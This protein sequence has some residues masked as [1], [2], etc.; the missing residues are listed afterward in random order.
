MK[1]ITLIICLV[2]TNYVALSQTITEYSSGFTSLEGIAINLN[3]EIYVSE[4]DSGKIYHLLSNGTKVEIAT[5]GGYA[6]DMV[7]DANNNLYIAEPFLNKISVINTN[8]LIKS[9]YI[10]TFPNGNSP[11]GLAIY[12]DLLYFSSETSGKVIQINANLTTT[13]YT[14]GLFTPEGIAFDSNGNLYVADRND[15][16]LF[17]ITPTGTKT[18]VASNIT[19]IRGVAVSPTDE[20]YFTSY[21][22]FP[23]E[24]KIMKYNPTTEAISD[25]VITSLDEPR[26]IEIDNLGNMYVTNIGNGTVTKIYDDALLPAASPNDIVNIPDTIFKDYLLNYGLIN[27]NGDD[28]IQVSEAN[29][30][31]GEIYIPNNNISDLTGIEYFTEI[32]SLVCNSNNLISLDVSKNTKL[33]KLSCS[34]NNITSLDVSTNTLLNELYCDSNSISALDI[35]ANTLLNKLYCS[36]NDITSLDVS[37]NTSLTNLNCGYNNITSLDVL[38]NTQLTN[39][40]CNGNDITNLNVSAN[41]L[42]TY[43]N[44]GANDISS[45][46]ISANT[47]LTNLSCGSNNITSLNVSANTLL[48]QLTIDQNDIS[49]IDLST[50]TALINLNTS[51]NPLTTLDV[52]K[53]VSLQ[54]LSCAN[55]GLSTLD[56]SKNINLLSLA[57]II[58]ELTTIDLSANESLKKLDIDRNKLQSLD[59]TK[60]VLLEILDCSQ[61]EPLT[62]I[63]LRNGNNT[64]ITDANFS[65]SSTPNLNCI[66]VDDSTYSTNNWT[67]KDA[68][69]TFI[70]TEAEC[71]T[72]GTSNFETAQIGIYPNP[73]SEILNINTPI[74]KVTIYNTQGQIVLISEMKNVNIQNLPSGLYFIKIIG[75]ND[76]LSTSQFIKQ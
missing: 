46:D 29:S 51:H 70:E 71:G 61:N 36:F 4:H 21:N 43:L 57:C 74:K 48:T 16:K 45:L 28:E 58:N 68:A 30:F 27:V 3:N 35:S 11:Y 23:V 6:N 66:Y 72:L 1:K 20:V 44:C 53:N 2:L 60:N 37:A 12:N 24:N 62:T 5:A 76:N 69:N 10:S 22:S 26:L 64:L 65:S 7:F 33:I 31:N 41:T 38:T 49:S 25:F 39:L 75:I 13:D 52:T 47:L 56:I 40:S 50:N 18:T 42:L 8:T 67:N 14:T 34:Y 73:A 32:Y 9:D 63:D 19:N 15:R 54:Y 59:L 55:N 17:K